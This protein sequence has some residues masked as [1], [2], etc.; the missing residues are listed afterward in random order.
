MKINRPI[1]T[2]ISSTLNGTAIPARTPADTTVMTVS[3]TQVQLSPQM[4][5][6]GGKLSPQNSSSTFDAK[7][8]QDIQLAI[9][10]GRFQVNA[11][12]VADGLIANAQGMLS[13][14]P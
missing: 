9:A 5:A 8:V 14:N 7:K 6:L 13:S 1:G 10:E 4:Q 2:P 12:K 3:A 11:G